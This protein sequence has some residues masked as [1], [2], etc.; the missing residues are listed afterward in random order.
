MKLPA[1]SPIPA[2]C[3]INDVDS[4]TARIELWIDEAHEN[5]VDSLHK[6]NIVIFTQEQWDAIKEVVGK[7]Q[8]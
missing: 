7:V 6:S 2:H 4:G 1:F 5:D 8:P 3:R